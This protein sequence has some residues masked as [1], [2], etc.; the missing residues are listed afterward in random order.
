MSRSW[1]TFHFEMIIIAM[2]MVYFANFLFGRAKN[3]QF[4]MSW[5][6]TVKPILTSNFAMVG[7]DGLAEPGTG[8]MIKESEHLYSLWCS[9]R[10]YC[11]A[12]L[13]ELRLLR[14]QCLLFM[15]FS[16]L[17]P[18]HDTVVAKV[19]MEDA[20]M[21]GWVMAVGR[22]RRVQILAKDHQDLAFFC[23]DKRGQRHPGLPESFT[24]L[25][26]IPE[27]MTSMLNA[28]VCKF[29]T[30]NEE[31]IEY[32]FFSDQYTGPRPPQECEQPSVL[33]FIDKC[34]VVSDWRRVSAH[35]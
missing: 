8:T 34:F 20:E 10:M 5:F 12:M 28:P 21:D 7:D 31:R 1:D 18:L 11:E 14:R 19:I 23:P 25:N 17:R 9:G 30:D 24:V 2:L 32:L 35:S 27:A 29:L 13:V 4:A 3:T 26:E 16:W 15:M 6:T 33:S 22:K